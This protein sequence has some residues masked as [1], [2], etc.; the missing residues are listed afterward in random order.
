MDQNRN[1][2][3]YDPGRAARGS[4]DHSGSGWSERQGSERHSDA[5][6]R[7]QGGYAQPGYGQQSGYGQGA[8]Q[9]GPGEYGQGGSGR[10]GGGRD[11]FS[12][13]YE[14]GYRAACQEHQQCQQSP[15]GASAGS[16]RSGSWNAYGNTGATHGGYS[17]MGGSSLGGYQGASP[18]SVPSQ[19]D[20]GQEGSSGGQE[21]AT[22]RGRYFGVGPANYQRSDQ[23]IQEDVSDRLMLADDIDASTIQVQV[24]EGEVTLEGTVESR[25]LK[26]EVERLVE[27][28]GGVK[29]VANR[30]RVA[31][32]GESRDESLG[33]AFTGSMS[34]R[35]TESGGK[36]AA[37]GT[38][39]TSTTGG[40][41][42]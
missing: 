19:P 40:S 7:R 14:A 17:P 9:G 20:R 6:S 24:K 10:S 12:D 25:D 3:N 32:G 39:S 28:V 30:L 35:S 21:R 36:G 4:E 8:S 5:D 37:G 18:A 23:R 26:F 38:R 42:G 31:R 29:D 34:G 13:G 41:K 1:T 15:G 22:A 16:S 33:S 2:P 27:R 11:A